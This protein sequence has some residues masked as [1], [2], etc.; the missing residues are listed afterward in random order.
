M[1]TQIL[2]QRNP[3]SVVR[4]RDLPSASS[5]EHRSSA[6]PILEIFDRCE[7]GKVV[8]SGRRRYCSA[9]CAHKAHLLQTRAWKRRYRKD[10]G[11]WPYRPAKYWTP[12]KRREKGR[13]YTRRWRQRKRQEGLTSQDQQPARGKSIRTDKPAT[14]AR[15]RA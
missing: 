2:G 12:E 3:R 11:H 13:E 1:Q 9:L 10:H 4:P 8:P 14:P 6:V 7:C 15:R 5:A